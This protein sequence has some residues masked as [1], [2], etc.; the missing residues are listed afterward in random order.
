MEGSNHHTN[1]M[2][3]QVRA[4]RPSISIGGKDY[5]S[6]LAPYLLNVKFTDNCDGQKGDDLEIQLADRD[7]RF[8]SDW[9]PD[10]GSFLDVEIITE[11][12]FAP[13]AA[14]LTLDCGRFWIDTVEFELPEH[15]VTI[16]ASS[17]PTDCH[18]KSGEETRGWDKTTLQDLANQIAQENKMT[19]DWQA[20]RNP[21]YERIEQTKETGLGFLM[22][23]ANDAKLAI[24]VCRSK[25]IIFD[26]QKYEEKG[27]SFTLL[28]G[29]GELSSIPGIGALGSFASL[30][31][32]SGVSGGGTTYRLKGAHFVSQI[33]DTNK[34]TT[35]SHVSPK[36]G[37]L[38]Q[39]QFTAPDADQAINDWNNNIN[40]TS[41][42]EE[43]SEGSEEENGGNGN[44]EG[45]REG[46]DGAVTDWNAGTN[47]GMLAKSKVRRANKHKDQCTVD[48]GIGNPLIAAGT[49][50]QL[51]GLGQFDG[52]WFI[53][54]AAHQVAEIYET[55]LV[56]RRCLQGY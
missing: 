30:L 1:T 56:V 52:K 7:N 37:Q 55:K 18:I 47:T 15:T 2:I 14:G 11:R 41:D 29:S 51:Q 53:E 50:C 38:K 8:I 31:S 10:K 46:G 26:E 43:D 35:I 39:Q 48:L 23:R 34:K 28:Y 25:I 17:I 4:A 24:K 3:T 12:W 42:E 19:V 20:D 49:T 45:T 9:M 13:F 44:G 6:Q 32:G 22:K 33:V 21:R 54:S 5:Y 16:K 27:P 40:Q 36:T